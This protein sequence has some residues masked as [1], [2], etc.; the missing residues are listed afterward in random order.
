M[1][2]HLNSHQQHIRIY[3]LRCHWFLQFVLLNRRLISIA[4]EV[5]ANFQSDTKVLSYNLVPSK[6]YWLVCFIAEKTEKKTDL[7]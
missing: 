6:R 3:Q 4:D 1:E 2:V 7:M 5:P